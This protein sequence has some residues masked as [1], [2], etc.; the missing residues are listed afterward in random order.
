MADGNGKGAWANG[1]NNTI[2]LHGNTTIKEAAI[3][4]EA[5]SGVIQ[6]TGGSITVSET[7]ASFENSKSDNN[8][9]ENVVI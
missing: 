5:N 3:G 9:L 4:L 7:G 1:P 2:E 8:K 6:M